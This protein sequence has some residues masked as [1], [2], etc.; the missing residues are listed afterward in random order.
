MSVET[1][2]SVWAL[3]W[4]AGCADPDTVESPGAGFLR[5]V[6]AAVGEWIDEGGEVSTDSDRVHEIADDA[7]DVY[8]YPRWLQFVDLGAWDEDV[9]E[10]TEHGDMTG[11]AGIALYMIAT[12]LVIE[13]VSEMSA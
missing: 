3:A 12:R 10:I 5:R 11:R 4:M 8:T 2:R 7:P 6:E 13:L 1:E 9:E